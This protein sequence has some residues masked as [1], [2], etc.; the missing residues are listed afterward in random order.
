MKERKLWLLSAYHAD[1]HAWWADWLHDT[2]PDQWQLFTLPGRHFR[3]RIRGNPLSWMDVLPKQAPD[4]IVATSMVDLA[5]LRGLRPELAR[6]PVLLYFHENQ[7]AYPVSRQQHASIDPQMV[8]LYA[9]LSATQMA[10]NSAWNRDSFLHGIRELTRRLPDHC[11]S[12][13]AER[14][15][16]YSQVLP[17]PVRPIEA[18]EKQGDL[19]LWNRRWEYDK[20]PETFAGAIEQLAD[21]GAAFRLALLG[22]C[23]GTPAPALERIRRIVADRIVIDEQVQRNEYR[24]WLGRANI[25]VS[26]AI[27]EFQGIA[28]LEAV[29]AGASPL[30]PDGLCYSAQYPDEYRYPA[31]DSNAL[32]Q[33]LANWLEQRPAPP[34]VTPY[35]EHHL[36]Q[37]SALLQQLLTRIFHPLLAFPGSQ[38]MEDVVP[39]TG[40]GK[41]REGLFS[42][43]QAHLPLTPLFVNV[44]GQHSPEVIL[45]PVA[46]PRCRT[47]V[48]K[49]KRLREGTGFAGYCARRSRQL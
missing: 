15:A 27:H 33:R 21:S 13:L 37:G 41:A 48:D 29:S 17:V 19:I 49:G 4:L 40:R 26:T 24:H 9:A 20:A 16:A 23:P 2:L 14:L 5:T 44:P 35:L 34:D 45:A 22:A 32:A 1:S 12:D 43:L 8:Q 38:W 6:T 36:R 10:F 11:P 3:W 42:R 28:I 30:V 18:G 39:R 46:Q 7:F 31:G 47:G 25:V